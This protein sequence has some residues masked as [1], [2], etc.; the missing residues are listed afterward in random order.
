[1]KQL[2]KLSIQHTMAN[3]TTVLATPPTQTSDVHIVQ[4]KNPK[5]T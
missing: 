1:M 5:A 3:Q 4:S 2:Q